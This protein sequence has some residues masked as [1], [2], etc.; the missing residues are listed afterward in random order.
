MFPDFTRLKRNERLEGRAFRALVMIP[1]P[2][3]KGET[4][5]SRPKRGKNVWRARITGR[6]TT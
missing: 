3:R 5:R 6:A 2:G 1:A 4:W